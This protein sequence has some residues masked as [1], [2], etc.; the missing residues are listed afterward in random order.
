M[1]VTVTLGREKLCFRSNLFQLIYNFKR[2]QIV[3]ESIKFCSQTL[4]DLSFSVSI[5]YG[6]LNIIY[7]EQPL[8]T[9]QIFLTIFL[10]LVNFSTIHLK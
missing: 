6:T 4:K 9:N 3:I 8:P 10:K 2:Q 7:I 5:V 1:Q